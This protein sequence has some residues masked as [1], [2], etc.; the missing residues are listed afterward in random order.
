MYSKQHPVFI[1]VG[2]SAESTFPDKMFCIPLKEARWTELFPSVYLK[3]E[4]PP[5]RM[6]FWKNGILS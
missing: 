1:V 5:G 4:W 6:F 3:F 2:L